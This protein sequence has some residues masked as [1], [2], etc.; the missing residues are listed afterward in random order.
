MGLSSSER[1]SRF[2]LSQ[3]KALSGRL[4]IRLANPAGRTGEMIALAL[5]QS[6]CAQY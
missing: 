5:M 6:H 1:N 4:A 3:L 2:L